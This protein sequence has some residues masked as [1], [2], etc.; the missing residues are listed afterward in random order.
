MLLKGHVGLV[1]GS[2]QMSAL[3]PFAGNAVALNCRTL[4]L[5]CPLRSFHLWAGPVVRPDVYPHSVGV[6]VTPNYRALYSAPV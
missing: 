3:S 2:D 1:V 4:F 6:A 5:C